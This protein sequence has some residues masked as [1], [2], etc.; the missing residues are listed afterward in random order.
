MET[1][2]EECFVEL[3]G[4][5]PLI[6]L[7]AGICLLFFYMELLRD[8]PF[9]ALLAKIENQYTIFLS[10]YNGLLPSDVL[11]A[12]E[13]AKDSWNISAQPAIKCIAIN[14][15]FYS[16]VILA[17]IGLEPYDKVQPCHY[18]TL[19]ILD[20]MEWVFNIAVIIFWHKPIFHQIRTSVCFFIVLIAMLFFFPHI[21]ALCVA[22]FT[23][24]DFYE[25][26][27]ITYFSLVTCFSGLVIVII[28]IGISYLTLLYRSWAL[29]KIYKQFSFFADYCIGRIKL[30]D[31]P[32]NIRDSIMKRCCNAFSESEENAITTET[33]KKYMKEEVKDEYD[34]F[35]HKWWL[36]LL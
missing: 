2:P 16:V 33:V 26:T 27:L 30:K 4:F 1:S 22:H 15:F 14:C 8:S 10:Q 21:N 23:V 9:K 7:W 24:G 28:R 35:T 11:S 6:Q 20:F 25:R 36:R 12:K 17:Y 34:A 19:Q 18:C 32:K 5:A 13:Y 31:L 3:T 29:L